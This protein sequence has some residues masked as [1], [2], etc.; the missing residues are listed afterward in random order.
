MIGAL[1]AAAPKPKLTYSNS[2]EPRVF[3]IVEGVTVYAD[4]KNPENPEQRFM[5]QV[6]R[7]MASGLVEIAYVRRPAAMARRLPHCALQ[8]EAASLP[9]D[10]KSPQ[11]LKLRHRASYP[12]AERLK[13]LLLG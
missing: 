7:V 6:F 3:D 5:A 8:N 2:R 10:I 9:P 4:A 13:A 11:E 1:M 12:I